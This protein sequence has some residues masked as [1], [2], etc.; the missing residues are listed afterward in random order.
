[1]ATAIPDAPAELVAPAE[2]T[3]TAPTSARRADYHCKCGHALR[4]FGVGRHRIY[5]ETGNA[6]LD[7]PVTNRACPQ[8]GRGLP[9]KGRP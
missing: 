6:R 5:F 4:V 3:V 8:C 9:G 2:P 7:D 1:M